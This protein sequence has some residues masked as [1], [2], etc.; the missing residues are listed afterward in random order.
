KSGGTLVAN[1]A[2][3]R[4]LKEKIEAALES[5]SAHC[6]EITCDWQEIR[7]EEEFPWAKERPK[8][9]IRYFIGLIAVAM[10]VGTLM[11]IFG[12]GIRELIFLW[13]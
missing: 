12:L 10:V 7:C 11:L 13:R 4:C 5:G 2:G 9:P 6:E 3:L 1:R 8:R